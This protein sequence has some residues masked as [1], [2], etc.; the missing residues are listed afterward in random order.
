MDETLEYT[1]SRG[2]AFRL[3]ALTQ[4]A[5]TDTARPGLTAVYFSE[6]QAWACDGHVL[7]TVK[8]AKVN[9][10]E[11]RSVDAKT[12]RSALKRLRSDREQRTLTFESGGLTVRTGNDSAFLPYIEAE[13]PAVG[14][15]IPAAYN[16][17][18]PAPAPWV[19]HSRLARVAAL[20]DDGDKSKLRNFTVSIAW[21]DQMK[22][23]RVHSVDYGFLGLVMPVRVDE[24]V[25]VDEA[26]AWSL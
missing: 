26:R 15:L 23:V 14:A 1:I 3:A 7:G 6:G 19:D 9:L 8:L 11:G 22:P 18:S 25:A 10:A 2:E 21:E 5:S 13:F 4:C 17:D 12:L 16:C 24:P 20:A